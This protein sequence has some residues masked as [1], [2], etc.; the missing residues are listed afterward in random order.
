[1]KNTFRVI[2]NLIFIS[3]LI[4]PAI[5]QDIQNDFEAEDTCFPR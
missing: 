4:V 3:A 2:I 5:Q 1:M